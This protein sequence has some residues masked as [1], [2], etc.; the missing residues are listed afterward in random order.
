MSSQQAKVL[1]RR[2]RLIEPTPMQSYRQEYNSEAL[3]ANAAHN[4][5]AP[6]DHT[7]A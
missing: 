3:R 4:I 6:L 1:Q 7:A 5:V 2:Y